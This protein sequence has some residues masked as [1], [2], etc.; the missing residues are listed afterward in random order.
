MQIEVDI[1]A[2]HI[3]EA[4]SKAV[5]DSELGVAVKDRINKFLNEEKRYGDS[6]LNDAIKQAVDGTLKDLVTSMIRDDYGPQIREKIKELLTEEVLQT[7]VS[8]AWDAFER[9]Y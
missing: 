1:E 2:N 5:V 9:R 6:N 8:K 4:V 7:L 3:N